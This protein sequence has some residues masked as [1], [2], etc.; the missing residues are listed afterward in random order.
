M[1]AQ[2]GILPPP[3]GV[4][5]NFINPTNRLQGCI[6]PFHTF[7]LTLNAIALA[8]RLYTR[9]FIIRAPLGIDD[10]I[11]ILAF[12]PFLKVMPWGLVFTVVGFVAHVLCV[13]L[14]KLTILCF[15]Y[16]LFSSQTILKILIIIGIVFETCATIAL[17]FVTHY[18]FTSLERFRDPTVPTNIPRLVPVFFSGLLGTLTDIYVL[19]LPIPSVLRLKVPLRQKLKALAIILL[20][21]SACAASITHIV[22]GTLIKDSNA[23]WNVMFAGSVGYWASTVECDHAVLCS[24]LLVLPVFLQ[25]HWPKISSLFGRLRG[26]QSEEGGTPLHRTRSWPAQDQWG[27]NKELDIYIAGGTGHLENLPTAYLAINPDQQLTSADTE[28]GGGGKLGI[29][30]LASII[31]CLRHVVGRC[32]N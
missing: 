20:G 9:R 7:Y 23:L 2:Q 28:L 27:L 1:S 24:C 17:I 5:S 16:R 18:T 8:M 11:C 21:A 4:E 6:I 26:K 25:H 13:T 22:Y 10:Y 3:P 15:Y 14:S 19:V 30:S 12:L 32:G 31:S 29:D